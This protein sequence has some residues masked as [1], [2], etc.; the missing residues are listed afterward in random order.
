MN[1]ALAEELKPLERTAP[2]IPHENVVLNVDGFVYRHLLVRLP[3]D[4][5]ADD[6]KE[7]GVWRKVQ[8]SRNALRKHDHLYLVAYD[9]SWAADAVVASG[10]AASAVLCKPKLTNFPERYDRLF[11]D[12]N[13]RVAWMGTGYIVERKK[14]GHRMTAPVPSAAHAERDLRN[15]YPKA[16]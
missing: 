9:E 7:P 3:A 6:L 2:L 11:E 4:F 5:V 16:A 8:G 15:I 13:Y 14:D 12:E 1:K 10:T